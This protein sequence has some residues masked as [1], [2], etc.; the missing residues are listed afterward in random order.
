MT[1]TNSLKLKILVLLCLFIGLDS[2][3]AQEEEVV[4]TPKKVKIK[5]SDSEELSKEI[6]F[7]VKVHTSGFG[8]AFNYGLI[9]SAKKTD[10]FTVGIVTMKHPREI[11]QSFDVFPGPL[12]N[13][14]K[15]FIYG[16]QNSFYGM[17]FGYG[18]KR[19]FSQKAKRRGVAVGYNF[20]GG[21]AIGFVKP[22]HL[23]L[24]RFTEDMNDF[25][26]VSEPY[27]EE[28]ANL[29]LNIGTIYGASGFIYGFG[30]MKFAF[31]AHAKS[32]LHFD[33]GVYNNFVKALDVGIMIEGY[34][35]KIPIMLTED[36]KFLF[37]NLYLTL[38]LGKRS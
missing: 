29:F 33:W 5:N 27:T 12:S 38:Q 32:G 2:L 11:K 7:D 21:P 3:S 34:H 4:V 16:K 20:S 25:E 24:I 37:V 31:G 36:N 13:S 9:R 15:A 8:F 22:Y 35:R 26:I 6:S 19:Y 28:N 18:G 14:P 17:H 1:I 10:M 30:K 23:D